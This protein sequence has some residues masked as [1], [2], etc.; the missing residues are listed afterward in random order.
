VGETRSAQRQ[1][2]L[3]GG[4]IVFNNGRSTIDCTVRNM[5][6]EGAKLA[7]VSVV[8][9]PQTFSLVIWSEAPRPCRVVWRGADAL[10]VD[11]VTE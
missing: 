2:V 5:S 3:K 10:G 6:T 1:R 7:V 11:F 9:I 4:R 8:G